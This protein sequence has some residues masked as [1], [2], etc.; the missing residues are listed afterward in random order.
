MYASKVFYIQNGVDEQE[1]E[2]GWLELAKKSWSRAQALISATKS[3]KSPDSDLAGVSSICE[4]V[5]I[6]C[7]S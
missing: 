1:R 6:V 5:T 4:S 7:L 3:T 2:S